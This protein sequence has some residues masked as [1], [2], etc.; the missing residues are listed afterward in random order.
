MCVGG[1]GGTASLS[2]LIRLDTCGRGLSV[3]ALAKIVS[4]YSASCWVQLCVLPR[5]FVVFV[6]C[7][8]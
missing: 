8:L 2:C 7:F 3:C 5:R 1:G 6:F 4:V